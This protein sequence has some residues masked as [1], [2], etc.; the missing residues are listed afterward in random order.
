MFLPSI[1]ADINDAPATFLTRS[2]AIAPRMSA[3]LV[4]TALIIPELVLQVGR[5]P[6]EGLIQ[7]LS[8]PA[9]PIPN[10]QGFGS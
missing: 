1:L 5:G 6:E 3:V 10:F 9:E 7:Q 2:S 4:E 8:P